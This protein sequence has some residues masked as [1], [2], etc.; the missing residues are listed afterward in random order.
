GVRARDVRAWLKMGGEQAVHERFLPALPVRLP[1]QA[2]CEARVGGAL[3][4]VEGECD[5]DLAAD[6]QHAR[7]KLRAS[8]RAELAGPIDLAFDAL[9]RHVRVE[10]E[11]TPRKAHG[12]GHAGLSKRRLQPA[13]ADIAPGADD[14]GIDRDGKWLLHGAS[15]L[16]QTRPDMRGLA[17]TCADWRRLAQTGLD[18]PARL[19]TLN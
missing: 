7:V 1:D 4:A 5:A 19:A 13:L 16:A 15:I 9:N 17:Q 8:R 11:R 14:I 3:H 6:G 18:V 10:L 12:A 2:V